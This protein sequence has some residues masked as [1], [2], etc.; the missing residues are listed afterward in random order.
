MMGNLDDKE[1]CLMD[2]IN[3]TGDYQSARLID[4]IC[5]KYRVTFDAQIPI[6]VLNHMLLEMHF[7]N[8]E[9]THDF[10]IALSNQAKRL[11][12]YL[13]IW[14]P[15]YVHTGKITAKL[16]ELP[17]IPEGKKDAEGNTSS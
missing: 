5:S 3:S 13:G 1:R 12:S 14:T 9:I 7:F 16:M 8:A 15:E 10:E 11:L 2:N 6:E 4:E 17:L